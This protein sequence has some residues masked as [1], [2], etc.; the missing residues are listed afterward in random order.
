V[1]DGI[2]T[3]GQLVEEFSTL[4]REP[5][6]LK[7]HDAERKQAE[8]AAQQANSLLTSIL[9]STADGIL[10]VG[11]NGEVVVF[12]EKFLF[13]WHIPESLAGKRD[14]KILL[15][16]VLSQLK[17]PEGFIEQVKQLYSQPEADSFDV[18]EFK[19]G[20]VFERYSQPQRLGNDIAGRVWSFRDVTDRRRAEEEQ[21]RNQEA[22]ERLAEETAVI[23]EIGRLIGST[24]DIDEVYERFA[25][26][27][28]KLIPLDS[29]SVHLCNYRETTLRVAYVFGPAISGRRQMDSSAVAGT[30]SDAVVR[31]RA[32]LLI[33]PEGTPAFL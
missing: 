11:N 1:K 25:V 13:L 32:S 9:E 26:E 6:D 27:T 2:K 20:R 16:H 18:L 30:V 28:R 12:N 23:A 31:G 4:R 33:Q 29:L 10:V 17:D 7:R 8:E 24:L 3:K 19:D 15:D 21:H 14:D 5:S 22:A